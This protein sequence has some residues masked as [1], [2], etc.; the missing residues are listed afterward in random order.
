MKH[1]TSKTKE[2]GATLIEV[3]VAILILS[4]GLLA[5]AA[6]MGYATLLPK[7]SA[8]RS[9]ATN[10]GMDMIERMRA[11]ATTESPSFTIS[12]YNTATFTA[13]TTFAVSS[14][15]PSGSTCAFP[16]CTQDTIATED[17]SRIQLQ[18]NQQLT[19]AGITIAVTDAT[20]N[21]GNL[22]VIWQ[23]ASTFGSY[24]TASGDNCP[25]AVTA[26]GL[27]PAPRCVYLPF[28]L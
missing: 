18:L 13:S 19:P 16:T 27:S 12:S 10:I 3:L 23:E 5:L 26:L 25:A 28:K 17:I 4:I 2:S 24:S 6:M 11:N 14:S 15:L 7:F 20:A 9:M 1:Y 8:N 21:E 22:W